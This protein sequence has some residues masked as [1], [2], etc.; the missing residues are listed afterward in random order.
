MQIRSYLYCPATRLDFVAKIAKTEADA[1]ILDLEDSVPPAEKP[2]ARIKLFDLLSKPQPLEG[3][4]LFLRLNSGDESLLDARQAISSRIDG[5]FLA[6]CESGS[7][8]EALDA[9]LSIIEERIDIPDRS[10][11]VVPLIESV[12]GLDS[13]GAIAGASPRVR[14]FAFGAGDYVTDIRGRPTPARAETLFPRCTIVTLSRRYDLEAPISHVYVPIQDDAG[15]AKA[16]EEDR[17]LGFGARS[18]I[19][20]RQVPTINACFAPSAEDLRIAAEIVA[21]YSKATEAGLGSVI[22]PNGQFVDLATVRW[23]KSLLGHVDS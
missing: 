2:A 4:K 18:C 3:K 13:I 1:V 11:C 9:E 22:A 10:I 7:E 5:V 17:A 14:R 21:A 23:A 19:H 12:R 16:C 8:I 20:P 6:K 15:L